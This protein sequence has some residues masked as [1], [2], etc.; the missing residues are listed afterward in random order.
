VLMAVTGPRGRTVQ[1]VL[2]APWK[3]WNAT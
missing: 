2:V 3:T 1:G